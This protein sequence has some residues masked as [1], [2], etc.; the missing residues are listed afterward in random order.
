MVEILS[1]IHIIQ[2]DNKFSKN[3]NAV[4]HYDDTTITLESGLKNSA[5]IKSFLQSQQSRFSGRG[6]LTISSDSDLQKEFKKYEITAD[7]VNETIQ[8]HLN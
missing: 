6:K 5:E 3:L 2:I 4:L 8:S 7:N 1:K